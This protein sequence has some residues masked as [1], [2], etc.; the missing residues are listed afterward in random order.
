MQSKRNQ[1][2]KCIK[3][4]FN[5]GYNED[6]DVIRIKNQPFR[7]VKTPSGTVPGKRS[8][9]KESILKFSHARMKYLIKESSS[10]RA[11]ACF[12]FV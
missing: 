4:I 3:T 10:L 6:R 12:L 8:I 2:P 7:N 1:Y 5:A 11:Y 9:D